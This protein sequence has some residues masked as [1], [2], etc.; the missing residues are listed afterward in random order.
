MRLYST[1]RKNKINRKKNSRKQRRGN[2]SKYLVIYT[3]FFG[4]S[5]SAADKVPR[6]PSTK[7]DCYFFT[8]NAA[9]R[10]KAK[11]AGWHVIFIDVPPKL[12]YSD[13]SM[14]AKEL[15]TCPHH[16][17]E[18]K[19][20]VYSCY[21][22]TKQQ[23]VTEKYIKDRLDDLKEKVVMLVAEHTFIKPSVHEEF[24]VAMEQPR[25]AQ[26]E[27][28]YKDFIDN[29]LKEG[30]KSDVETHYETNIILRRSGNIVD[31]IGEKWYKYILE[32]GPECQIS[33]FF[34]QQ[35][36]KGHIAPLKK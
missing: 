30:L 16:F 1:Q 6:V 31:D 22:D 33:F 29:K 27:K 4:N 35:E 24:K 20:Y 23:I 15:K 11:E 9:T 36:F 8:N 19:G 12:S 21:F 34:I 28:K 14:D 10:D 13:N 2:K 32:T 5:G 26:D 3:C 18:L 7:Y 17:N 25:Y